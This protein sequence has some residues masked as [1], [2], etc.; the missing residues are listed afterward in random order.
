M[1]TKEKTPKLKLQIANKQ[2]RGNSNVQKNKD[3]ISNKEEIPK[4]KLQI[5]NKLQSGYNRNINLPA[6]I[7]QP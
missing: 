6:F 3:Q 5:T 2:Q 4:P 7:S 1:S